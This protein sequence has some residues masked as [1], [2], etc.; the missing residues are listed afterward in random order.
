MG[1]KYFFLNPKRHIFAW[2]CVFWRIL[3]E[4]QFGGLGC[5]R[6]EEPPKKENEHFRSYISLIWGEKE[7][8]SDLHKILNLGDIQ[9]V[10][11]DAN[12]GVD[13]L[14]GFSMARGQILGF[15]IGFR[16]RPHNTLALPCECVILSNSLKFLN[17]V[18][19][20]LCFSIFLH[21]LT[22]IHTGIRRMSHSP[23]TYTS[24]T[25]AVILMTVMIW[26]WWRW[27]LI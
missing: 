3:R 17:S 20:C 26:W 27:F 6:E 15:S 25:V 1:S 24:S 2:D 23:L 22:V 18:N 8:L 19:H 13:R 11:T 16:R 9:D 4:D 21:N 14:R 7:P 5:R 10:I 12:F